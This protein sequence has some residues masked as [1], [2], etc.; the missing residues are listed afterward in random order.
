MAIHLTQSPEAGDK[1]KS[2]DFGHLHHI[3]ALDFGLP[4]DDPRSLATLGGAP[5]PTATARAGLPIWAE[6]SWV[7]KLYPPGT[8]PGEHLRAYATQFGAIE[9][10]STHYAIPALE[11]LAK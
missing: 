2:I 9:L 4:G 3:R 11:Q 10:N 7:G 6:R 8:P 5:K 1:E